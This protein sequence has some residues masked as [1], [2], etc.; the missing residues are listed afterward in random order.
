M[1]TKRRA[2]RAQRSTVTI[3]QAR[4]SRWRDLIEGASA[5]LR[6]R[7]L[8]RRLLD[9]VDPASDP[10][11]ARRAA[12]LA[13][14]RLRETTARTLERLVRDARD[15]GGPRIS[16]AIRPSRR[17]VLL[18]EPYLLQMIARLRDG[19][20]IWPAGIAR[21]RDMVADGCGPLYT[22]ERHG[23]L[24]DWAQEVLLDFDDGLV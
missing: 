24:R 19:R 17:E 20:P 12:Q 23:A 6:R 18:A 3:P 1:Q 22:G 10:L 11:V 9:G 13:A 21:V 2:H 7:I 14:P 16:S 8:E 5:L 15:T 4:P